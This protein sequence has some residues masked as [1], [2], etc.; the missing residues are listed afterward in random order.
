MLRTALFLAC[1]ILQILDGAFTGYAAT[2]SSL[3]LDV[4]GNPL[5]KQAMLLMGV[6][7]ALFLM[8]SLAIFFLVMLNRLKTSILI[9]CIIFGLY[10]PV[11]SAWSYILFLDKL[12]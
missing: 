5:V 12:P 1:I 3:G 7:P 9:P 4:E 8:K 6:F 11:V 10:A 2:H